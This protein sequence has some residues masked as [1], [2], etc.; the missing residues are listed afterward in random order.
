MRIVSLYSGSGGNSTYIEAAGTRILIDAGK[1]ARRLCSALCEIGSSIDKIDAIFITHE[2]SDHISAL[3]TLTKKHDIPIHITERSAERFCGSRFECVR[4]R[5]V[6]H[7]P[8]F[9]E[10]VGELRIS[11]FVTPHDSEMSVGYRIDFC[12]DGSAHSIGFATDVGY[13]T[14][15][16]RGALNGCEAVVLEFNHDVEMLLEGPYPRE[17]KNRILSK[18]GHLSNADA[19]LFAYQLTKRG[20]RAFLL[21]HLSEQNNTPEAALGEFLSAVADSEIAVAVASPDLP[22]EINYGK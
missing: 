3:E 22:T 18:R 14:E 20:T 16:I 9:C 4:N 7:T 8:L 2:H 11:S 6:L 5:I 19:A 1:S 15:D 17:L 10:E 21:A 12:E 13:V